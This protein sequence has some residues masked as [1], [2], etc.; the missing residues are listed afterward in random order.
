MNEGKSGSPGPH[1][2]PAR[3]I[4]VLKV[5]SLLSLTRIY[6]IVL[7]G[8]AQYLSC[9][10]FFTSRPPDFSVLA[11]LHF[12]VLVMC[13]WMC[14]AGGYIIN[15]FYDKN[16]DR[17]NDPHKSALDSYVT[18]STTLKLYLTLNAAAIALSLYVSVR[19]VLFFTGFAFL[20]WFYSHKLKKILLLA[21]LSLA[22][23]AV[24][25]LF[26]VFF[27]RKIV[28][29]H[30]ILSH[31]MFLFFLLVSLSLLNDLN[32]RR[33]DAVFGYRTLAVVLGEKKAARTAALSVLAAALCAATLWAFE[34]GNAFSL[35]FA[36]AGPCLGAL[37]MGLL[38][39]PSDRLFRIGQMGI[40][41]LILLGL[42]SIP[43]RVIA[44]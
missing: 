43:L 34:K 4:T 17:I 15:Y 27:Y 41:A 42:L 22:A 14:V 32:N 24:I 13:T 36:T 16:K 25:L 28:D 10:F 31:G 26:A 44:V 18:Q 9:I 40:K 29:I 38:A 6:N 3:P 37:A 8:A 30:A 23:I 39:C 33:G 1:K 20:L 35:Y 5:L 21:N 19:S 12:F 2:D 11:D 7:I